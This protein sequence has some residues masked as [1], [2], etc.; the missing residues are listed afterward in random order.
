MQTYLDRISGPCRYLNLL[1]TRDSLQVCDYLR[2]RPNATELSRNEL[3]R[4]RSGSFRGKFIQFMGKLNVE[5]H[6]LDWW[7]M[8]FTDKFHLGPSLYEDAFYFL[9]I[10]ELLREDSGPLVVVVD[11]ID[12]VEQLRVWAKGEGIDVVHTVK[13]LR[14][15]RRL[16]KNFTPAGILYAAVRSLIYWFIS[17][18]LRPARNLNEDNLVITTITHPRS[19]PDSSNHYQDVY[20]GELVESVTAPEKQVIIFALVVGSPREQL[21]KLNSLEFKLPVVPMDSCM[22]FVSLLACTWR[23]LRLYASPPRFRGP[24]SIDGLDLSCLVT[25]AI[26][27]A[28]HSGNL[29]VNLRIF[30]SFRGLAKRIRI[31]RCIYPYENLAREK[32]IA[33][34]IRCTTPETHLV[35]YQ[36]ASISDQYINFML[37]PGESAVTPLPD[38][39]LTTGEVTRELLRR[40][41]NYPPGIFKSACALRQGRNDDDRSEV[42]FHGITK[43]FVVLGSIAEYVSMLGFLET[44]FKDVDGYDLRIR[45]HPER[46]LNSAVAVA[47]LSSR[48]FFSESTASLA[49]DLR[50]ADVVLYASSTV[51]LEA[52]SLGTPVVYVDLGYYV[53]TD[54]LTGWDE[55]KWSVSAPTELIRSIRDIAA[56]PRDEFQERQKRGREYVSSYMKPVTP[57]RMQVFM[58]A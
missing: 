19:F 34:G 50:W 8:P 52:I 49:D 51:A 18:R 44:A 4:E 46:T 33:L 16:I 15:L 56:I 6:S 35:G 45:P 39:I 3:F 38:V 27:S 24:V 23:A 29:L 42:E 32:M 25:Q 12:L 28:R 47:P 22:T 31:S 36:H 48:D 43:V 54:P 53:E 11:S 1:E 10:V 5:N 41:G 55:F 14:P 9:L 21:K 57:E 13:A 26:R 58:D 37:G 40:E 2:M 7:A 30:Y 20:F 17:R